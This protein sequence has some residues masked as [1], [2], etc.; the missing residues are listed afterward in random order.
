MK[1]CIRFE[2][3]Y[4]KQVLRNVKNVNI[5]YIDHNDDEMVLVL[6]IKRVTNDLL[7]K[8]L[9]FTKAKIP[10]EEVVNAIKVIFN[11]SLDFQIETEFENVW[12]LFSQM[13]DVNDFVVKDIVL[14]LKALSILGVYYNE[15]NPNNGNPL[16]NVK[17]GR[18]SSEVIYFTGLVDSNITDED[19]EDIKRLYRLSRVAEFNLDIES[20]FNYKRITIRNW[21]D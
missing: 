5:E 2:K 11:N 1:V 9:P 4:L 6:D 16:L 3:Q 15:N 20:L 7:L 13:S 17:V 14:E 8:L 10:N 21:W 18:E 19:I 12:G